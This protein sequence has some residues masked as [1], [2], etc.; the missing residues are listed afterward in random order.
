M[1]GI[2]K[3]FFGMKSARKNAAEIQ[4]A[5]CSYGKKKRLH[6]SPITY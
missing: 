2:G 5:D 4:K 1:F 3:F 6:I